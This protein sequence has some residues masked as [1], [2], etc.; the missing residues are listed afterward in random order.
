MY[1][2]EFDVRGFKYRALLCFRV[3]KLDFLEEQVIISLYFGYWLMD[4][5]FASFDLF[6]SSGLFVEAFFD[7]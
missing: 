2:G 1:S 5:S 6:L 4:L 7:Y 3:S